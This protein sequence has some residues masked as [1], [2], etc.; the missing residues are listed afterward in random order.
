MLF[1]VWWLSVE[2]G[3]RPFGRC[4]ALRLSNNTGKVRKFTTNGMQPRLK[5]EPGALPFTASENGVSLAFYAGKVQ[6]R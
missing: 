5:G 6:A 2:V 1:G 3:K 4:A